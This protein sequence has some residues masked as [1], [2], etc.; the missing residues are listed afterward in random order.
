METS[1]LLDHP[2]TDF[3]GVVAQRPL[4][5]LR[6]RATVER[7]EV[8][9]LTDDRRL[10]ALF[11]ADV[12]VAEVQQREMGRVPLQCRDAIHSADLVVAEVKVGQVFEALCTRQRLIVKETRSMNRWS[13][14][15]RQ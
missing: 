8:L 3:A 2:K 11:V 10:V 6:Q 14:V 5:V 12:V 15:C 7:V 9:Q 4:L 13:A 1:R